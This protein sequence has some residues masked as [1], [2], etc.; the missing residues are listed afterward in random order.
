MGKIFPQGVLTAAE[1][2]SI[3][4]ASTAVVYTKSFKLAWGE[5]FGLR[6][7][8]VSAGGTPDVKIELEMGD[9]V[10]IT[11]GA[12]DLEYVEPEAFSD[13]ETNLTTE[14]VHRKAISPPPFGYGRF[15]IT[16]NAANPAD[17]IVNMKLSIYEEV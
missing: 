15:K 17:T 3:A 14:T 10:P 16:G 13:I 9:D 8:A 2:T 1:S 7:Q 6:Y 12:A 4:I 5:Y 11:E